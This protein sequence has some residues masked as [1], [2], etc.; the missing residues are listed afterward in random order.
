[1]SPDSMT[2][3]WYYAKAGA[4]AGHEIGPLSW[5]EL[6]LLALDGALTPADL[7]WNPKLPRGVAAGQ[8]PGLF[9]ASQTRV[10]LPVQAVAPAP[11]PTRPV[12]PQLPV[13]PPARPAAQGP[14][15]TMPIVVP[16]GPPVPMPPVPPPGPVAGP[17]PVETARR[18]P[19]KVA[20]DVPVKAPEEMPDRTEISDLFAEKLGSAG[21][22]EPPAEGPA[23]QRVKKRNNNLPWLVVLLALVIAAA[24]LAAYFLYLRDT[25]SG[26][27]PTTTTMTAPSPTTTS[28]PPVTAPGVWSEIVTV[29]A[30]PAARK[31]H[32]LVYDPN[33][34]K[35]IL[36]GGSDFA[37]TF[38]DTWAFDPSTGDWTELEPSGGA[39]S[40]REYHRMVYDPVQQK[41]IMFGG[42]DISALNDTWAFDPVAST[43]T[44][45]HP[46]GETPPVRDE[47][48]MI[49]DPD[50]HR[51]ILFG[52]WSTDEGALLNDTWAY[53]PAANTWTR[54]SPLGSQPP[55]RAGHGLVYEPASHRVILFGGFG[56]ASEATG[57]NLNDLWAY[58]LTVSTWTELTPAGALPVARQGQAMVLDS[59]TGDLIVHGGSDG[60]A[61]LSDTWSYDP[62]T[63]SWTE[64]EPAGGTPA[65]RQD[66]ALVYD[67]AR[68]AMILFG[69]FDIPKGIHFGDTWGYGTQTGGGAL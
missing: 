39:P 58:D 65:G 48:A 16:A 68:A 29:G 54:L 21:D 64:L 6:Y 34:R 12:A 41:L 36:F 44:E 25:G 30:T 33:T 31:G 7:V 51:V 2:S 26:P 20:A 59:G 43:W 63:N 22:S 45:L 15:V 38:G 57:A 52:G 18:V 69:G 42:S 24:G 14:P 49:Y 55:K 4:P 19:V 5:Q 27:A 35:A 11:Q 62:T 3:G 53:D 50:S 28:T 46:T 10:V 47:H 13:A 23:P 37:T 17:V 61:E 32:T 40:A 8:I 56:G 60:L 66:H 67:Q 1:M 9:P